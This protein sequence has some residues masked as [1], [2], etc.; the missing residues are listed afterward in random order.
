MANL[1]NDDILEVR[2][3]ISRQFSDVHTETPI[4]KN[5]LTSLLVLIDEQIEAAEIAIVQAI[6]DGEEKDWLVSHPAISR[7]I[8][9]EIARKRKEVL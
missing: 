2:S 9:E 7:S 4:T 3:V 8:V 5:Q 6:P 1:S